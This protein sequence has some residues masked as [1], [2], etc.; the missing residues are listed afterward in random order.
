MGCACGGIQQVFG[1][2]QNQIHLIEGESNESTHPYVTPITIQADPD[3]CPQNAQ[4]SF[5]HNLAA[6]LSWS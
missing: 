3:S 1:N 5:Q 2:M 4:S 6:L